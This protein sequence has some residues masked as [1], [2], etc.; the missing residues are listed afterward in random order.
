M[1]TK[2]AGFTDMAMH[3]G[4]GMCMSCDV[5]FPMRSPAKAG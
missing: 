1:M 4:K 2:N 3:M 5:R